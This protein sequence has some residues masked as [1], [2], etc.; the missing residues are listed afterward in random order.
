MVPVS[1]GQRNQSLESDKRP[2]ASGSG[3][4]RGSKTHREPDLPGPVSSLLLRGWQS[5]S[6]S[7]RGPH[8]G[9]LPSCQEVPAKRLGFELV[10]M[11]GAVSPFKGLSFPEPPYCETLSEVVTSGAVALSASEFPVRQ[12]RG[13]YEG[14]YFASG[15][16]SPV[17]APPFRYQS[18]SE[19]VQGVHPSPPWQKAS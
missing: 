13:S 12:N 9:P 2:N 19:T 17:P 5:L 10:S 3:L 15:C 7:G 11:S 1:A 18:C 6:A 14:Q 4:T 8:L 16:F